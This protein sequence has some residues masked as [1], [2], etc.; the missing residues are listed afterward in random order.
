MLHAGLCA[1]GDAFLLCC[2]TMLT[3]SGQCQCW[4]KESETEVVFP[5]HRE[6]SFLLPVAPWTLQALYCVDLGGLRRVAMMA[7]DNDDNMYESLIEGFRP[8]LR[9]LIM[10]QQVLEHLH[11]IDNEQRERITKKVANEGD[12]AAAELLIDAVIGKP[13]TLGW[14]RAFVVALEE[15]GCGRAADYIQDKLPEPEV[16][17][18]NDYFVNLVQLMYP[19]LMGMQTK[20][21]LV[22]CLSQKLLTQADGEIVSTLSWIH[23]EH[24]A[25][26]FPFIGKRLRCDPR[27]RTWSKCACLKVHYVVLG[28]TFK[29]DGRDVDWLIILV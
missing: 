3:P 21:V 27:E 16:E 20:E 12:R 25:D 26:Q 14:F 11:I 2:N 9:E 22:H 15:A 8:R 1:P 6:S 5:R 18:E 23:R 4:E 24:T 28:K 29:A 17:A 7:S 13:H 19:R 10:V